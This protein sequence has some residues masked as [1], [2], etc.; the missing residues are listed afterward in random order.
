[1]RN[2]KMIQR[3][4][5]KFLIKQIYKKRNNIINKIDERINELSSLQSENSRILTKLIEKVIEVNDE[6]I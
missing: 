4:Y 2:L 3:V 6:R 5:E 1:M